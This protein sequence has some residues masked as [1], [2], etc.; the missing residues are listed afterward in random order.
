MIYFSYGVSSQSYSKL[1][2]I[3]VRESKKINPKPSPM[4]VF[5]HRWHCSVQE[6]EV[7]LQTL[8]KEWGNRKPECYITIYTNNQ[9]QMSQTFKCKHE[10]YKIFQKKDRASHELGV[11]KT[12]YEQEQHCKLFQQKMIDTEYF[13]K[14]KI[15]TAKL[16]LTSHK[17][18]N[19]HSN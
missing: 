8:C 2:C 15:V 4:K 9:C 16:Q 13:N 5:K 18:L 7:V 10:S 3:V 12:F 11:R 1:N 14:T 17:K 19:Q 6:E